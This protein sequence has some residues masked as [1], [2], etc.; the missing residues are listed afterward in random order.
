MSSNFPNSPLFNRIFKN[1]S[2]IA[3]TTSNNTVE[4]KPNFIMAH[5]QRVDEPTLIDLLNQL[6][7]NNP[8][9]S[10]N[11]VMKGLTLNCEPFHLTAGVLKI[12]CKDKPEKP[13]ED[14]PAT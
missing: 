9:K 6:D 7:Y 5:P 13:P 10:T 8:T 14:T 4:Q 2:H 3:P 12:G 11:G 1:N